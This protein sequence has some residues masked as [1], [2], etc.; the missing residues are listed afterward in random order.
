MREAGVDLL[1][2]T[3]LSSA[4]GVV[5]ALKLIGP[6]LRLRKQ[7]LARIAA[8]PPDAVIAVDFGAFNLRVTPQIRQM[9]VPVTYWFPPGSWRRTPPSE[10]IASA[11]DFFIS[12]YPWYAD[13]LGS[14]GSEAIFVGHP[15]IDQ[16][17]PRLQRAEFLH[18]LGLPQQCNLVALL[19]GSRG[20]EVEHILPALVGAAVQQGR[21]DAS[22][23]FVVALSDNFPARQAFRIAEQ[24][25]SRSGSTL[26]D[27]RIALARGATSESLCH[28]RAAAICSGSATLEAL[29]A[30]V[31][32]VIVYRGSAMMKLEYRLRR[33]N[34]K[35]MGMPNII[36]DAPVVPELR[37]DEVT[38]EAVA[39]HLRRFL[40]D[41]PE[42]ESQLS[43]LADLR[44]QLLPSGAI[45][46]TA[47]AINAW[48]EERG[49]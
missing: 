13:L 9:D 6:L 8:D 19:P 40:Q 46:A 34:I 1:Y 32:M 23:A 21:A 10:R 31:P 39:G 12:P 33:M 25:A 48:L 3:S 7:V 26:D 16:V 18:K 4:I 37:Q 22:L 41:G 30:G 38:P 47:R 35:Y 24:A 42:R 29:V 2:D 28:A 17:R 11:A 45:P 14:V 20:H 36:A 27:S 15:L 44:T 43:V 49:R 5:Q